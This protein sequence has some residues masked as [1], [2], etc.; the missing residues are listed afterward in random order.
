MTP[1]QREANRKQM[2]K[3]DMAA[4]RVKEREKMKEKEKKALPAIPKDYKTM[5]EETM[6]IEEAAKDIAAEKKMQKMEDDIR[7]YKTGGLVTTRG[8]G[9]VMRKKKTRIC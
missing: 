3:A 2:E 6:S 1:A 8:Q 9:K 4:Q 7:G 5:P